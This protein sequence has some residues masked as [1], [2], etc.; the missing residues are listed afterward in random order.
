MNRPTTPWPWINYLTN[1]HYCA[2]VSQC[3]GGYSFYK[4]CRTDR[5]T[6]WLPENYKV[7]RPGRYLYIRDCSK[8]PR[9]AESDRRGGQASP[10]RR[11]LSP[12]QPVWSAT[13][14]P[15]KVAPEEF[16]ARHGIGYTTIRS[17]T[18]GLDSEMTFFVPREHPCEIWKIRLTNR[19]T[20]TRQ[21]DVFPY[22]EW[23]LGDYH[24]ELRYRN[25]MN[26]YN[27]IWYEAKTQTIF[28]KKTAAWGDFNIRPFVGAAFF[29]SSLPVEGAVT[30]KE[31]FLGRLQTEEAPRMLSEGS[32]RHVPFCSGEDGIAV[33][34]HRIV[35]K[36]QQSLEFAVVMGQT[37][38]GE[39]HAREL[40]TRYRDLGRVE[41]ELKAV[42][43]LWRARVIDKVQVET[44]DHQLDVFVNHWLKYELYICNFWSRSPSYFHEGSGGRG[45]RDSCQDADA[46]CL[47]NPQHARQKILK[48]ASL[49]RHDGTCAPG[50][51]DTGGP[52]TH[53]PN[54]DH[55]VWLTATVAGYVKETGDVEIL[56]QEIPYLKDRWVKGWDID[57]T[58][59]R[60]AIEEGRGSLFEHL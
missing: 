55:P 25:I 8:L 46:I 14:Q 39:E 26:L 54:K 34:R 32:F 15:M 57:L 3:A 52:A 12:G 6:R 24:L 18:Y 45:Y 5:L 36:P 20:R 13:Y 49:I 7:D 58:W 19:S 29:A 4:D 16:E 51:S 1:E 35:L 27:R 30:V 60:G 28:A 9:P 43:Q 40:V 22:V 17:R 59:T 50:W 48:L 38:G 37:D 33:V 2:I 56:R 11:A 21:L 10:A 44:P 53:R 41:E 47:I 31:A 23:L 42:K